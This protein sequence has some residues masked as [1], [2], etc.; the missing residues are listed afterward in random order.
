MQFC[1]VYDRDLRLRAIKYTEEGLTLAQAAE[2]FKHWLKKTIQ[3][4]WRL[5]RA[6]VQSIKKSFLKNTTC[7][8]TSNRSTSSKSHK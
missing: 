6:A 8:T 4:K 2:V 3:D 7:S 1:M 5:Q